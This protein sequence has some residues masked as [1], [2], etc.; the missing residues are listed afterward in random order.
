MSSR[1]II[2]QI[3]LNLRSPRASGQACTIE[4]LAVEHNFRIV[5]V[6]PEFLRLS[7][8][9]CKFRAYSARNGSDS[10]CSHVRVLG[11]SKP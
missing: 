7:E 1:H 2:P 4:G 11:A 5:S 10:L 6:Y 9:F 8:G 3:K